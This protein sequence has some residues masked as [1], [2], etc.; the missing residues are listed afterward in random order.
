MTF[1]ELK[2]EIDKLTPEQLAQDAIWWG[3]RDSGK[4]ADVILLAEDFVNLGDG[5]QPISIY[6]NVDAS[7]SDLT[8]ELARAPRMKVGTPVLISLSTHVFSE[9]ES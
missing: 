8:D 5:M 9:D 7:D 1:A 3:S 6:A 4:V 2:A